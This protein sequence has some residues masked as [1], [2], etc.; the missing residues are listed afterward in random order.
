MDVNVNLLNIIAVNRIR[1]DCITIV[2]LV[3]YTNTFVGASMQENKGIFRSFEFQI[4][5]AESIRVSI[6]VKYR[7]II[8]TRHLINAVIDVPFHQ[9]LIGRITCTN[10]DCIT[11]FC[12]DL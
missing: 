4:Q 6:R 1:Y 12:Y 10:N 2:D 3:V 5:A 9:V 8:D 11:I 7:V